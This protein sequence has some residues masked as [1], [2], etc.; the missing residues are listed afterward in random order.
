MNNTVKPEKKDP[1][2]EN[3]YNSIFFAVVKPT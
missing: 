3:L 1:I 2:C